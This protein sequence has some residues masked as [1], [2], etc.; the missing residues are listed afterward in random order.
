MHECRFARTRFANDRH[1]FA[2]L[3]GQ[4]DPIERHKRRIA[5]AVDFSDGFSL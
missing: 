5:L 4:A 1:C 2:A 3:N